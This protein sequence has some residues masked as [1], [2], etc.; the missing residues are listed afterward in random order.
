M[1]S[2]NLQKFLDKVATD[3][4]LQGKVHE[5]LAATPGDDF[6]AG[7]ATLAAEQQL[8]VSEEEFRSRGRALFSDELDPTQLETISGGHYTLKNPK[9]PFDD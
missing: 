3:S 8:P 5:V 4:I 9:S 1:S 6:G 7:L 2:E